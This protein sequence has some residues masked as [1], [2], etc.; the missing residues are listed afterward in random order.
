MF[1]SYLVYGLLAILMIGTINIGLS[2]KTIT[3]RFSFTFREPGIIFSVLIF[4]IFSGIR[5]DVGVDYFSYYDSYIGVL[6]NYNIDIDHFEL[7]FQW[8]IYGL[9]YFK[10]HYFWFF[11]LIALIQIFFIYYA[12]KDKKFILPYLIFLI[13]SGGWYFHLMNEMRQG[14][15]VAMFVYA[16]KFI[17]ERRAIPYFIIVFIGY[18]IH[19]SALILI[20]I[21]FIFIINKDFFKNIWL[22][23]ILLLT[24]MFLTTTSI[25][26]YAMSYIEL[27]AVALSLNKYDNIASIM[28]I[29]EH[30][31]TKGIRYYVPFTLNIIII[32]FSHRLKKYFHSSMIRVYYNLFI[33]GAISSLLFYNNVLMQRPVRYFTIM[34]P[35]LA[36]YLL[37]YLWNNKRNNP[38]YSLIFLFV[39]I[40]QIG[41]LHVYLLSDHHTR[42][43]FF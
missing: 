42:F 24:A 21:Y 43:L 7:G 35:I 27:L 32:I 37:C 14:I 38:I 8:I 26:N 9:V 33:L 5:H 28:N 1:Q 11:G 23:I 30:S 25:W 20:P 13:I 3:R 19:K 15:V 4:A 39:I 36:A 17:Y 22:Q 12:F 16:V 41:V 10:A 31:F 34:E 6:N 29:F 40:L 2:K 18:F